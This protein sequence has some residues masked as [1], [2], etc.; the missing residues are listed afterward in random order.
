MEQKDGISHYF[1]GSIT[2]ITMINLCEIL[3]VSDNS[4]FVTTSA[5]ILGLCDP[6]LVEIS[7]A[8]LLPRTSSLSLIAYVVSRG[9]QLR[10]LLGNHV[11]HLSR[12]SRTSFLGGITFIVSRV[13]L[14]PEKGLTYR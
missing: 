14:A 10:R 11:H 2:I 7:L 9:D 4:R 1:G 8:R 13:Q 3:G 6:A 12:Q 5:Q